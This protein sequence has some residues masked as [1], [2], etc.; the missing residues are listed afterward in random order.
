MIDPQGLVYTNLNG[1]YSY[2][3]KSIIEVGFSNAWGEVKAGFSNDKFNE[4]GGQWD[5]K[6]E[7]ITINLPII[8]GDIYG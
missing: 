5:Y 2:S 7:S 8:G 1:N 4:R 6:K 3:K